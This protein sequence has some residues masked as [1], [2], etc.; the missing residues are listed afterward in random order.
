MG[1]EL[2]KTLNQMTG[3]GLMTCKTALAKNDNDL[4][5]AA[6]WLRKEGI[7]KLV[8]KADRIA[9]EGMCLI[10]SN[11]A[12]TV[13]LE[14]NCETDFVARCD[15]FKQCV[16]KLADA[17]LIGASQEDLDAII[18]D[19]YVRIREKLVLNKSI[20]LPKPTEGFVYT[21]THN[22]NK[23]VAYVVLDTEDADLGRRIA[24]QVAASN[25]AY[26][27]EDDV[28]Q[29]EV[30]A[31]YEI[32]KMITLN[33]N[34]RPDLVEKITNN[35]VKAYFREISLLNQTYLFDNLI[36][37]GKALGNVK[38]LKMARLQIGK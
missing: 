37:V 11:D 8:T 4:D 1:I 29:E 7:T 6:E 26:I 15:E 17:L 24:L 33:E 18:A 19:A 14:V 3:A 28:S 34:V 22:N 16:N 2:I 35:R 20:V 25:P 12:A 23:I 21:Y 13:L 5:K 10:K 9:S 38:V 27:T 30:A 31:E 36:T 32:Q